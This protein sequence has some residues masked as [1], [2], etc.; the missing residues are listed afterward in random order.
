[1][2]LHLALDGLSCTST[3]ASC[4]DRQGHPHE[5]A[6]NESK[7]DS[8]EQERRGQRHPFGLRCR[9]KQRIRVELEKPAKYGDDEQPT[10]SNDRGDREKALK[11]GNRQPPAGTLP[12]LHRLSANDTTEVIE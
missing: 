4:P 3:S 7:Y 2:F 8:T 9:R 10:E 11:P 1:M 12:R 6:N 5:E